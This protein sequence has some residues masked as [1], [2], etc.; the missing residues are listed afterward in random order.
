[1]GGATRGNDHA[2]CWH[3]TRSERKKRS[4][5]SKQAYWRPLA[6]VLIE[7]ETDL[8]LFPPLRAGWARRGRSKKGDLSG[9]NQK[10]VL[11]G[12]LHPLTGRRHLLPREHARARDF[13][14]FLRLLRKHY[15]PHYRPLMLILDE[16]PSHTAE[17]SRA[18]ADELNILLVFLPK[19]S[20]HLNPMDH[21]WR[22]AKAA[23]CANRQYRDLDEQVA[24]VL[25]Y[26][27]AMPPREALLKAGILSSHFWLRNLLRRL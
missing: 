9:R 12:A 13:C 24:R 10:R 23:I 3:R 17:V 2:T 25:L 4:I 8:L 16:H 22:F 14:A 27:F 5:R 18:L 26:L 21:L 1:M 6:T 20:P 15:R 11:F 19:R 7:D